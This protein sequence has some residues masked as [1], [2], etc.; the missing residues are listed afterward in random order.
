MSEKTLVGGFGFA[1]EGFIFLRIDRAI[2]TDTTLNYEEK[3]IMNLIYQFN[4][5]N[6]CCTFSPEWIA[7]KFGWEPQFVTEIVTLLERKGLIRV[8]IKDE[9]YAMSL[10]LPGEPDPCSKLDEITSI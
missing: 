4:V 10:I 5:Q 7:Y 2:W 9:N 6:M 3:I 8:R 1:E